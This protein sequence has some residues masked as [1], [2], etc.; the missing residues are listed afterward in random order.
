MNHLT[1]FLCVMACALVGLVAAKLAGALAWSW[2]IILSPLWAVGVLWFFAAI[3]VAFLIAK[4]H[5]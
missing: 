1:V 4:G 3:F 5:E 2:W